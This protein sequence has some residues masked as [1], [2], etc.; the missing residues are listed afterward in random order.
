MRRSEIVALDREDLAF[1]PQGVEITLRHSKTNQEGEHEL[2]AIPCTRDDT[3]CPV[4]AL[5]TWIEHASPAGPLFRSIDR[6]GE[7]RNRLADAHVSRIV[8][9]SVAAIAKAHNLEPTTF[10]SHS[11]RS[12]WI[13]TA[14]R[15]RVPEE[16]AMRHSR[17]KSIPVFRGYVHR[18]SVWIDHPSQDMF[19]L[20]VGLP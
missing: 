2:V 7:L 10:A 9:A 3:P 13:T 12:G 15:H 14:V 8:K 17:H 5:Q 19:P 18:A 11:L 4:R 1:V 20:S 6:H 16:R